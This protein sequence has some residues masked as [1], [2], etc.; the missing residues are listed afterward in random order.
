MIDH[1]PVVIA[2]VP[3]IDSDQP[4]LAPAIL[5]SALANHGIKS[6][7]VD[8]NAEVRN[9]IKKSPYQESILKFLL[10]EQVDGEAKTAIK[11][12][13]DYMVDRLLAHNP[14]WI[15]LSLLTY[16][17]QISNRWICQRIRQK[18]PATKIVIGGPGAFVTLKAG[19][20][21]VQSLKQQRLIDH[22]VSGDAE[23]SFISLIQ[24][25]VNTPGVDSLSWE[26]ISDLNDSPIPNFDDYDW[27]LYKNKRISIVGSRGCVRDCS[28]CDIHEH[29]T[30]FQW[31]TGAKIFSEIGH[32]K[33]TYGINVF[34]FS[35]SLVNGNQK[36][37]RDWIRKLADYNLSAE[38]HHD[39]ISWT[40]SFIIRPKD[41]MK[42]HDWKLVADSGVAMLSVGVESFVEHIRYHI[43]KRFSN[44][45]LRFALDM[46]AK[47]QIPMTLLMIVGYVTETQ[48]DFEQQLQWVEHN[49]RY[50]GRPVHSVQIGS[51]LGIL[52]GTWLARN[53]NL[54]GI[55]VHDSSVTQDWTSSLTGT[56][57]K[58]RMSWHSQ[59]K[60]KLAEF[61]FSPMFLKDNHV[62]IESYL[63]D[64]Y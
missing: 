12:I 7:T 55:T 51:G 8:L 38:N 27:S 16:L 48:E 30:K 54:L 43:R 1:I 33:S 28:F 41:L 6:Y 22:Y 53:K 62:L 34:N 50:A 32:L 42:E 9:K 57:P 14:D 36:E 15:A 46:A 17:S 5:K 11:D 25:R 47:Y 58:I 31:K 40:G 24:G 26:Q 19:V 37:F 10:T 35:D 13:L 56:T 45:D 49:R 18:S 4:T 61:G 21:Y 2:S 44:D 52:P 59:M 63:N 60:N 39:R 64:K 29:W 23:I 20:D 3:W